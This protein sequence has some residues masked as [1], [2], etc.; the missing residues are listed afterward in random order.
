VSEVA[1]RSA[2]GR[3]RRLLLVAG[4]A[5]PLGGL[6]TWLDYVLPGLAERGWSPVLGLVE[7]ARHHRPERMLAA[8]PHA[9]WM[10]IPC[11]TGTPEGRRRALVRALLDQRPDVAIAVNI[12]DLFPALHAARKG[13]SASRG[14]LTV[15]GIEPELFA[16][17][18][19]FRGVIDGAAATNRL[20]CRLLE[21]VSGVESTRV[22]YAPYGVPL[23]APR[24]RV[25]P[26]PRLRIGYA[27]RLEQPQ[28]RVRDLPRVARALEAMGIAA[29]WRVAGSGPEEAALRR[30]LPAERATFLGPVPASELPAR[31]Y[32]EIDALLVPSSWETGPLV[33]WEAMAEGVPVVASRYVGSGLEGALRDGENAL[34]FDVGDAEGAAR[35]LARLAAEPGLAERLAAGGQ[36]LLRERFGRE[37]SLAA[38]ER[39][40][41][42]VL[43]LPPL[44]AADAPRLPPAT[45]RFERW[46]GPARAEDARRLLRRSGPNAG[47]GGEWPHAYA[48]GLDRAEFLRRAA[49]LDRREA[50]I[51][52]SGP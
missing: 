28:K 31:L 1:P 23:G 32:H 48:R 5:H 47:S 27:G 6:A 22:F 10:R 16:D 21:R 19:T 41:E 37:R 25:T 36:T 26:G 9:P 11:R 35:R 49:E 44:G 45:G 30:E 18:A 34:L 24:S 14:L 40:L 46:L 15:H 50:G 52:C 13:G 2:N 12:P 3:P 20:A 51:A 43:A 17:A 4:S 42:S 7:G 29:E 38:W 33:A 8:H 39:A